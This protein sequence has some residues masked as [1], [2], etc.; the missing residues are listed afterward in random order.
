MNESMLYSL[1]QLFAIMANISSGNSPTLA[2]EF[3]EN[4]LKQQFSK[5]LAEKA[6]LVFEEYEE[7]YKYS[8]QHARQKRQSS[9]SVKIIGICSRIAGE[10]NTRQRFLILLSLIRFAK[11]FSVSNV[12]GDAH[13]EA[14][15][16]AVTTVAQ[17]LQI[18]QEEYESCA[19]FIK[20][21]FYMVPN[22]E[23]LL[24]I[25]DDPA[26]MKGEVRHV[27]KEGLSGQLLVLRIPRAGIF[28][29]QYQ[30]TAQLESGQRY[31]FPKHVWIFPNG[32][33]I[34]GEG[35][36]PIYYS[37]IQMAYVEKQQE[38]VSL[39]ARDLSYRFPNSQAGIKPFS[40]QIHSGQLVGIMGGSGSGKSTLLKVLNGSM[41]PSTGGVY[42]NGNNLYRKGKD[43]D[44]MIG[45]VPQDD[46]LI[47]ELTVQ[48]NLFFSARLCLD[49]F[50]K[51]RI[52]EEVE[53]MLVELDL[54][55]ARD[56]QVGSPLKKIISGGQRKRLNIALELI[57]EPSILF[58]DEPTSGLSSTDSE[59]VINLLK[60][61]SLKGKLVLATIHQ[62]SSEL[63]KQFDHLLVLDKGGYPVYTGNPVDGITY[64]KGLA[65]RVDADEDECKTCGNLKPSEML[66]TIEER[67][68]DDFGAYTSR[69]KFPP[70]HWYAQ[71]K[72]KIESG[73]QIK[74]AKTPLPEVDFRIPSFASQFSIFFR[75][76]LLTKLSD[77]QY[78]S[79]STIVPM[80]LALILGV[81]CKHVAGSDADP[82]LY[83]FSQ[84]E[85]IPA[86]LFMSV[87][88]ALFLGL[89][90]SAEE[91]HHDRRIL[92]RESFLHLSRNAYLLS[93][94][95]F[96]MIASGIQML[97]FVLVANWILGVKGMHLDY[98]IILFSA[99]VF[100]NLLGLLIS[101][102]IKSA[103][104][105]YIVI[106]FL[107]V[108]QI[109]LAGVIIP[110]ENFNVHPKASRVVPL[111]G[112]V[113]A[114][115]WAYEALAVTQF[116]QNPYQSPIFE[117]EMN[118][119]NI[120]YELQ[121]LVPAIIEKVDELNAQIGKGKSVEN[122]ASFLAT[123]RS[124]LHS[125]VLTHLYP[126]M[127]QLEPGEYSVR[128]GEELKQWLQNYMGQLSVHL[129]KAFAE[130][131]R[132][133]QTLVKE[134]GGQEAF[135]ASKR[136]SHNEKLARLVLN[137][138]EFRKLEI[139]DGAF[140]RLMDPAYA[141]PQKKNGRAPFYSTMK[142]FGNVQLSTTFVNTMAIW[143][144][145]V[146][147]YILLSVGALRRLLEYIEV[148]TIKTHNP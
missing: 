63:F 64:F 31:I 32:G 50:E 6:L 44:G 54:F 7:R 5:E 140:V 45:Y 59:N 24:I 122:L 111:S 43:L 73:L 91:I 106:P 89:I 87:V 4:Y 103:V 34:K 98:W 138:D 114:S 23:D 130:K 11:Y 107:L 131:D 26:F 9:Y 125:I 67:N 18:S 16:D 109:L 97:L 37:D 117:A 66:Q 20:D 84:N 145:S 57:R 40:F 133:M 96:L 148:R 49:G 113:M 22:K 142:Q 124:G 118:E 146:V 19:V 99:A 116:K 35:F 58:V 100:G 123:I 83:V 108:P 21:K 132:I 104:A 74:S 10:L 52:R 56:L 93:K 72:E 137:R 48:Q 12:Q 27:Q 25:S 134:A 147:L 55:E 69:R 121:F 30:G 42:I 79:L 141:Y 90:L 70:D 86:Y 14:L 8:D 127:T 88:V 144:M 33:S 38:S 115:R 65:G 28:L 129:N 53:S 17:E 1:M 71:F 75:R 92:V 136:E 85:S 135:L 95:S 51:D 3:V 68:V 139:Q 77:Q 101:D 36:S 13:G 78:V 82:D 47:E 120:Q 143:L 2:R 29:F 76:N 102:G 41:K 39:L 105:I 15:N 119:S 60:Q 94:V 81:F 112:D 46:L 61:Q 80:L 128:H 62:P 110:F 126:H